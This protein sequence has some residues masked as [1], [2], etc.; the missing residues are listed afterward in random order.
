MH[1]TERTRLAPKKGETRLH[2]SRE[3]SRFGPPQVD[4]AETEHGLRL[5]GRGSGRIQA[6][7]EEI[8]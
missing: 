1:E 6:T 8:R 7:C 5:S 2:T 4:Q 3:L